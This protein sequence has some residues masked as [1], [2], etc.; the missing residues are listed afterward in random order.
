MIIKLLLLVLVIAILIAFLRDNRSIRVSASKKI[1]SVLLFIFAFLAILSPNVTNDVAHRVGVGRGADLL[2]YVLT[3]A[4]MGYLVS[5]YGHNQEEHSMLVALA[6]KIAIDE[7]NANPR[8]QR[9]TRGM[10]RS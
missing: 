8:N 7:G 2:L 6:R 10:D 9:K 4:F 1:G 3:V 5:Q